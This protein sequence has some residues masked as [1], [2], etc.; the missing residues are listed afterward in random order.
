M[1]QCHLVLRAIERR[2]GRCG[3]LR[4]TLTTLL[5][6]LGDFA[7]VC[8]NKQTTGYGAQTVFPKARHFYDLSEISKQCRTGICLPYPN[9]TKFKLSARPMM[10]VNIFAPSFSLSLPSAC[11]A[12]SSLVTY[13]QHLRML[14]LKSVL[15]VSVYFPSTAS[16]CN[17]FERIHIIRVPARRELVNIWFT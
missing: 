7:C 12:Y 4:A 6:P 9:I 2:H 10:V 17:L 1:R 13:G 14:K 11:A 3:V 16:V 8:L 15:R 5:E